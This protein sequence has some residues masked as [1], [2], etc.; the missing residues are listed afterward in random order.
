MIVER[1]VPPYAPVIAEPFQV[2]ELTVPRM[3]LVNVAFVAKRFVDVL[4]VAVKLE[5]NPVPEILRFPV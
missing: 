4:F 5:N 3:L 2:P 1:P